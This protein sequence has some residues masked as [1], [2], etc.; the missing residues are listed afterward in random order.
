MVANNGWPLLSASVSPAPSTGP[1]LCS[2]RKGLLGCLQGDFCLH[3]WPKVQSFFVPSVCVSAFAGSSPTLKPHFLPLVSPG[4]DRLVFPMPP[5]P[6][7][8]QL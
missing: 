4:A 2:I 7:Q 1:S 5:D 6:P 8:S 3:S